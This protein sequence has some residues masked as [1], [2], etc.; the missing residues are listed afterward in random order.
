MKIAEHSP[1]FASLLELVDSVPA[2]I[3]TARSDGSIDFFNQRWLEFVGLRLEDLEGWKWTG[4]AAPS[5]AL[6]F[7]NARG[8]DYLGLPSDHP[9]RFGVDTGAAW[10][11]E[12]DGL[13]AGS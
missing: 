11:A 8:A 12:E 3:H 10:D 9:I 13:G 7:V 4:Y 2:L 1:D 5:G 6:L